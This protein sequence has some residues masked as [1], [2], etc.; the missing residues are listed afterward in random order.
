[1]GVFVAR[2]LL[3]MLATIVVASFVFFVA[4]TILPGDPVRALFGAQGPPPDVYQT[5]RERYHLD[6]PVV[7]QYLHFMGNLVTGDLGNALPRNPSATNTLGPPIEPIVAQ[8]APVSLRILGATLVLEI[9]V[10]GLLAV[11]ATI[12]KRSPVGLTTYAGALLVVSIPVMV[13]AYV[14]QTYVGLGLHWLPHRW[15]N[16]AGWVNYVLPVLALSAGFAG[17]T[18]LI[19]RT[20]ILATLR[21]PF[22]R[23]PDAFGVSRQRAVVRHAIKPS[24]APV[25]AFVTANLGNLV[26]GLVV[27]EAIFDVPGIGSVLF[28]ALQTPDRILGAVLMMIILVVVIVANA[29]GDILA[30]AIDPRI[31]LQET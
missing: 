26:A 16:G 28:F 10:G 2:R 24:V 17:Y 27:V 9:V 13:A 5:I 11:I 21:A 6:E 19:G 23:T 29:I 31:R 20:E 22:M 3:R 30:S 1:M 25:I 18:L 12:G 4:I 15:Y 7:T 14:L 8:T